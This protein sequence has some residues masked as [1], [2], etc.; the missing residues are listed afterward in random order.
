MQINEILLAKGQFL[1]LYYGQCVVINPHGTGHW[2]VGM[3]FDYSETKLRLKELKTLTDADASKIPKR[4][5]NNLIY[6]ILSSKK[7]LEI[8]DIMD[9]LT[10]EEADYLRSMGYALDWKG[11]TVAKQIEL[12][13]ITLEKE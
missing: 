5:S 1:G 10:S 8:Y 4:G 12:G 2:V 11:F 6:G 7:F 9:L 3:S 13:W